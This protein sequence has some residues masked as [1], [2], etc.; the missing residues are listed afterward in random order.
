VAQP[1][2]SQKLQL[3]SLHI[4]GERD[5]IKKVAPACLSGLEE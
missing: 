1:L 3:P 4:I 2:F 5:Q